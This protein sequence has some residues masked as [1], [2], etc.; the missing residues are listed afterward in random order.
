MASGA[1][2]YRSAMTS[3][4]ART[5]K[6]TRNSSGNLPTSA[7]QMTLGAEVPAE[8][9]DPYPTAPLSLLKR[10]SDHRRSSAEPEQR[11]VPS[12]QPR[13]L[14]PG[15]TGCGHRSTSVGVIDGR[16]FHQGGAIAT[17]GAVAPHQN[18]I[19]QTSD[20]RPLRNRL[21]SCR[22][23]HA[24]PPLRPLGHLMPATPKSAHTRGHRQ[25]QRYLT[26]SSGP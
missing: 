3:R 22:R 10:T 1:R 9:P 6:G 18:R 2:T 5:A 25:H 20:Q 15:A 17:A 8:Q 16:L 26:H 21:L 7:L 24:L 11:P 23:P 19:S 14:K 4:E 12:G 13:A